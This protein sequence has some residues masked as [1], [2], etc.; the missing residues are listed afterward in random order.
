MYIAISLLY[1]Y[2]AAILYAANNGA[3]TCV[4]QLTSDHASYQESLCLAI[5]I[6]Y[7]MQVLVY[8]IHCSNPRGATILITHP[9]RGTHDTCCI[10]DTDNG[11][12]NFP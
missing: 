1:L 12:C 6:A 4:Y 11:N 7:S 10:S 3:L 8:S 2:N 9:F 5:S